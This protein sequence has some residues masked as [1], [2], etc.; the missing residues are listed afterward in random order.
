MTHQVRMACKNDVDALLEL[1][2]LTAGGLTNFPHDRGVLAERVA[3]SE[4]S[5][6]VI[7]DSPQDELVV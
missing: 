7:I 2:A 4:Q 5:C 3:W 6:G 1:A